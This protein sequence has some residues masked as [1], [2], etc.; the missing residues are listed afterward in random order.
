MPAQAKAAFDRVVGRIDEIAFGCD[1]VGKGKAAAQHEHAACEDVAI[2][3]FHHGFP[4]N[5]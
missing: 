2:G 5:D 3:V 1:L 4:E